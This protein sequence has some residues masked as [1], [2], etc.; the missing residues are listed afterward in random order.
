ME[1]NF[2]KQTV[3]FLSCT[4]QETLMQE[5][6]QEVI[7][8]DS[9]PDAERILSANATA[10]LRTQECRA[11]SLQITGAIRA[12]CLYQ[13][14]KETQPRIIETYFPFTMRLDHPAAEETTKYLL[15]LRVRSAEARMLNSRK[16][17]IR[18]GI[19]CRVAGYAETEET[20]FQ[21]KQPPEELQLK[22]E[23]YSLQLPAETGVKPFSMTE[24]IELGSAK[25]AALQLAGFSAQPVLTNRKLAGNKAVFK[26]NLLL[27]LLYQSEDGSFSTLEE[28]LPFSQYIEL[29]KDYPENGRVQVSLVMTGC[30]LGIQSGSEGRKLL[31]TA[32]LLSQCLVTTSQPVTV[33][34]D[35]YVTSGK[36]TPEW[37]QIPLRWGLD[38]QELPQSLRTT[39]SAPAKTVLNAKFYPDFPV[40]VKTDDGI[41]ITVPVLCNLLYLNE[42]G[43]TEGMTGKTEVQT[44][45]PLSSDAGSFVSA[46]PTGAGYASAGSGGAELRY[47]LMLDV[48]SYADTTLRTLCG[49]TVEENPEGETGGACVILRRTKTSQFV[50][51]IAKEYAT[52]VEAVMKANNLLSDEVDA[53]QML[54][55]PT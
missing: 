12:C 46:V 32:D 8:P 29:Q 40:S 45:I 16:L 25:P 23:V 53:G 55:I 34:E 48:E 31:L 11:G 27:D 17:L 22:S 21:I 10:V 41:R 47:D 37:K 19:G 44:Q 26:G 51:D 28:S 9:F 39:V 15:D 33:Y 18:V 20:F 50:W 43:E 54:L 49:G 52:T 13:P 24:E 4:I 3:P 14:E 42:S 30:D 2:T 35:A 5:Q 36:F 7:V 6:T 38:S 1:L